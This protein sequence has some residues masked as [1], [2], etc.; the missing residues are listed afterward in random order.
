MSHAMTG[1]VF[2]CEWPMS[3]GPNVARATD[4]QHASSVSYRRNSQR[5][6]DRRDLWRSADPADSSLQWL[7]MRVTPWAIVEM[8]GKARTA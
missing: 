5:Q 3:P 2:P 4:M 6:V 8:N 1:A 7:N